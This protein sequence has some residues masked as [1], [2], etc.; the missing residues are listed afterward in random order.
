MGACLFFKS[1]GSLMLWGVGN[2]NENKRERE[3]KKQYHSDGYIKSLKIPSKLQAP[4][5]QKTPR[6]PSPSVKKMVVRVP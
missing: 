4:E 1:N 3:R 2:K 5:P 6:L